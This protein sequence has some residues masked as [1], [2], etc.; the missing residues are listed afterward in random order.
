MKRWETFKDECPHC[1]DGAEVL[2]DSGRGN[3][4]YDGDEARCVSCDCPGS[5]VVDT[6]D[7]PAYINWHDEVDCRCAWCLAHPVE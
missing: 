3:F 4:A 7:D 5:V 6:V 2:T 1:G